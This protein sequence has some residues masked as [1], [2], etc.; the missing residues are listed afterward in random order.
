MKFSALLPMKAR[1]ER[2]E[3]KN[4]RDFAGIPLYH[5]ICSVLEKSPLIDEILINTD[6]EIIKADAIKTFSKVKI[7]DRPT[8]LC[9]DFV[10]MND[11]IA[12]DISFARNE[13][14]IQTH[15]TNPLLSLKTLNAALEFYVN[16]IEKGYFDSVFSATKIQTRFYDKNS[17]P[18]NHDPSNLIRTQDLEP[19]FE[20]NSNFYI[21]SK[22]SF[23]A[24]NNKRIGKNAKMFIMDKLE[25]ID[26]D[27]KEDFE[28]AEI[29]YKRK[30]G[31]L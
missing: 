18:I 23:R 26:I 14:L 25:A 1:S 6:S 16:N 31:A 30:D 13:N 4:M 24:A 22:E 8:E 2:V 5:A 28:L 29:L 21:F 19:Y 27:E 10:S 12:Y 15:S 3:N 11:I 9:G 20:E 17:S 7:I